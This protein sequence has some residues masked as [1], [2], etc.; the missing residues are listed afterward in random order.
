[1]ADALHVPRTRFTSLWNEDTYPL[2]S[3]AMFASI[4][5]GDGSDRELSRAKAVGMHSIRLHTSLEDAYDIHRR[6][7]HEWDGKV[8]QQ[9]SDIAELLVPL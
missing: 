7:V 5:V 6:D 4:Y 9:F 8:V 1:M 2:R 3:S